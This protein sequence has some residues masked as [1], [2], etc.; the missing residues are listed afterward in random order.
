MG[1]NGYVS[2]G[3]GPLNDLWKYD[4]FANEWTWIKGEMLADIAG[5]YGIKGITKANNNPGGRYGAV[6]WTGTDGK[7]CMMGGYGYAATNQQQG[8]LNDL[9]KYDPDTNEWTWISGDNSLNQ[10]GVYGIKGTASTENK[11]GARSNLQLDRRRWQTLVDG[12]CW[13]CF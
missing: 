1:G 2:N 6:S 5:S 4:P 10:T 3:G 11:P 9:W 8:H 12:W 13:L 7:L